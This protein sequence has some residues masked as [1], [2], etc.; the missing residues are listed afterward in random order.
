MDNKT[1]PFFL[2]L[3]PLL[4]EPTFTAKKARNLGI[5][6]ALLSHYVKT[7]RLKRIR[8]GVYQ[9]I[10]YQNAAGFRWQDL[11]EEVRSVEGGVICLLSALAI[12]DLTEEIPRQ[13][14]IA[15]RHSTSIKESSQMKIVR[16]RDIQLGQTK[17]KVEGI[18][19]PI[20]DRERTIVDAFRLLSLE[21]AIKAL[22]IALSQRGKS[23]LDLEKLQH[24]ANKLRV[25]IDPYLIT[26]MT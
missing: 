14:W 5:H 11:I 16:M 24:Y 18:F 6:P 7:H 19:V 26:A 3:K 4:K 8:R 23:R 15:V 2:A 9:A 22:K 25:N 20:F 10:D 21:T 17:L 12:Y 13:H 1:S